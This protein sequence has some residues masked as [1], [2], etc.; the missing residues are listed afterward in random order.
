MS[1]PYW[2]LDTSLFTG[3]FRYFG[4]DPV[5][6]RGKIHTEQERYTRS[7]VN[8]DRQR[9]SLELSRWDADIVGVLSA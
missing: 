1:D 2:A 4:S 3:T 6:V 7:D 5:S 8:Q 9:T